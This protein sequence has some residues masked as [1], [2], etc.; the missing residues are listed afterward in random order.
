MN[1]NIVIV[2]IGLLSLPALSAA[3]A[4]YGTDIGY[5][6]LQAEVGATLPT[7]T[8]V[9]VSHVEASTVD[10]THDDFPQYAPETSSFSGKTFSFP[11]TASNGTSDHATGVGQLFYGE[12]SIAPGIRNISGHEA[13]EWLNSLT[14]PA[15][16][17][18]VISSR[19]ANHSWV[20][21]GETPA[22]TRTILRWLDRQVQR[23]EYIQVVGM[24]NGAGDFPLLGSAYNAIAVGRTDGNHDHGSDAVTGDTT[25]I[26]GRTRPD[27][28]APRDTTSA[29]TPIVSAAAVLLV[30][31]G[32]QGGTSL[33]HGSTFIDGIDTV[34]N[35]ERSETIKAALM[36]GA[37]RQTAN[38][39]TA[40][41]VSDYRGA[42]HPTANGLD[43]RFG[44]GQL[45]IYNSYHILAA[46]EQNSRE[47]G[48]ANNGAI[49]MNGFDYDPAFGG[50][51]GSN[52]AAA[53]LFDA[54]SDFTLTASLVW[55]LQV[56]NDIAATTRLYNLD[57]ALFD[58]TA[59][60]TVASSASTL[61]N[62][63]NLWIRLFAGHQ[64][65][66]RIT[67]PETEQFS[68]DYALA[69]R[70]APQVAP[71][72]IPSAAWLFTSAFAA[73]GVVGRRKAA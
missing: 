71:I 32:H 41:N 59:Q 64:Y 35:A 25:Y 13:G 67:T 33:S 57:L 49:G 58:V 34:Y 72:P 23:N 4:D 8:G 53:Y 48:G 7:G 26:A 51:D 16:F 14:T 73:M 24:A 60:S 65:E 55:N 47:D 63:E 50:A 37:E 17:A 36:A 52:R 42:G 66:L 20:G 11:G 5:S 21:D 9:G 45:N 39:S 29:A 40:A 6:V 31:T 1:K 27:I 43:D 28:V 12:A 46:G 56:T 3:A 15:G 18:S 30:E 22:D 69:W 70:M 19:I 61:D 54:D 10:D 38:T 68:W 2:T 44:A 62:T